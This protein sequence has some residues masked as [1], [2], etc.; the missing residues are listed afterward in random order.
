MSRRVAPAAAVAALLA[1]VVA[2]HVYVDVDLV[3][4]PLIAAP[5]R[6]ADASVRSNT[7][8]RP[9][10][11]E[12]QAPFAVTARIRSAV[13][14]TNSFSI[15]VDGTPICMRDLAG[16]ASRRVDCAVVSNWDPAIDHAVVRRGAPSD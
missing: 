1:L 13:P 4:V 7:S 8:R 14:G 16:G 9:R 15:A 11:N 3:R 6:A 2:T 10:A 12:L 5:T